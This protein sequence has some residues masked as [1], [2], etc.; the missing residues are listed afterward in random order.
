MAGQT[1]SSA[2]FAGLAICCF[3]SSLAIQTHRCMRDHIVASHIKTC[4]YLPIMNTLHLTPNSAPSIANRLS[5]HG[6]NSRPLAI[7]T[8]SIL[9]GALPVKTWNNLLRNWNLSRLDWKSLEF[10]E[11]HRLCS[12]QPART[13]SNRPPSA[14]RS[15][16]RL[17]MRIPLD[18]PSTTTSHPCLMIRDARY[19]DGGGR[20]ED[21][22]EK[23]RF[24]HSHYFPGTSSVSL[25]IPG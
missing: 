21:G 15:N 17:L 13:L 16:S 19:R 6:F 12:R 23:R 9:Y 10:A 25:V 2:D 14:D 11:T 7:H 22:V 18:V 8:V 24:R 20:P 1:A 4:D 3:R 5:K